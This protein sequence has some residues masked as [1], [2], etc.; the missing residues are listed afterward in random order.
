MS[1]GA[2]VHDV[3][4]ALRRSLE[5]N[6]EARR[7]RENWPPPPRFDP[8]AFET[9]TES[10]KRRQDDPPEWWDED[11]DSQVPGVGSKVSPNGL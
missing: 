6:R 11:D 7:L 10:V 9:V 5:R 1:R 4:E 2:E 8:D 3:M